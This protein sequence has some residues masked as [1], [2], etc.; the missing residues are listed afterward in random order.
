[1]IANIGAGGGGDTPLAQMFCEAHSA[2][3]EEEMIAMGSGN[4]VMCYNKYM[5]DFFERTTFKNEEERLQVEAIRK[6]LFRKDSKRTGMSQS[7]FAD[8][9]RNFLFPLNPTKS[10]YQNIIF[11]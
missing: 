3:V 5:T 7:D 8:Y 1:M 2:H 11:I 10:L 9:I 6:N 4:S